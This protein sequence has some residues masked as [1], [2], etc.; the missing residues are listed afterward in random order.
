V[1]RQPDERILDLHGEL[2]RR[3]EDQRAGIRLARR[4]AIAR[5]FAQQPLDDRRR[6]RQRL[7][8]AR[9]G[10]RDHVVAFE[11][12]RNHRAL[13]RARPLETERVKRELESLVETHAVEGERSRLDVNQLPRQVRRRRR[14][15][16][17]KRFARPA[18]SAVTGLAPA[19]P[20]L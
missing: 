20:A 12:D 18:A 17:R 2:A 6:E 7:A 3:R 4:I 1:I 14:R 19:R 10:A 15:P 16:W 13:H 5:R 8:G 9:L 11:R